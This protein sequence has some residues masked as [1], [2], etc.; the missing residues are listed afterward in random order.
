MKEAG[1]IA[2][3]AHDSGLAKELGLLELLGGHKVALALQAP[4]LR[5]F[6][7]FRGFRRFRVEGFR[8]EGLG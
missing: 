7:G 4:R 3:L 2:R 1:A 6:R 5:G 8:V